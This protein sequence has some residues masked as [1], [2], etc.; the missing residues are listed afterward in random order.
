MAMS[1]MER[2]RQCSR[3]TRSMQQTVM[4]PTLMETDHSYRPPV[5]G[6]LLLS[7]LQQTPHIS[8]TRITDSCLTCLHTC[9][10]DLRQL[11]LP[12]HLP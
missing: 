7:T 6:K 11:S 5:K 1:R 3:P 2:A 9:R 8:I 4:H 12:I 10:E